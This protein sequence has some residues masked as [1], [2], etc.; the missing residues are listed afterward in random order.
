MTAH[1]EEIISRVRLLLSQRDRVIVAIDG[2]TASGTEYWADRLAAFF[3]GNVFHTADFCGAELSDRGTYLD[4]ERLQREVLAPVQ[5]GVPFFFRKN[6]KQQM[7]AV[8][9]RKLN[10]VEG[11]FALHHQ[12][13]DAYDLKIMLRVDPDRQRRFVEALEPEKLLLYKGQRLPAEALY[14]R[15]TDWEEHCD[16]IVGAHEHGIEN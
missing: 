15:F 6:G 4:D 2:G 10:I 16:F 3:D 7:E 12:L 9:P 1:Y 11:T 13:R 5:K 14:F 8:M